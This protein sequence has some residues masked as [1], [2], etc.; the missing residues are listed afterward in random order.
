[1]GPSG[2]RGGRGALG[3]RLEYTCPR[4][5]DPPWVVPSGSGAARTCSN[6]F[7]SPCSSR[8]SEVHQ[9]SDLNL[10]VSLDINSA[11]TLN[12]AVISKAST[13]EDPSLV[14]ASD[15]A[16]LGLASDRGPGRIGIG[17]LAEK[18]GDLRK[19]W[20]GSLERIRATFARAKT[21]VSERIAEVIVLMFDAL[22]RSGPK[23]VQRMHVRNVTIAPKSGL[24]ES[25]RSIGNGPRWLVVEGNVDAIWLGQIRPDLAERGADRRKSAVERY[26]RLSLDLDLFI[27]L[28][29]V[30]RLVTADGLLLH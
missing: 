1:V 11:G 3:T 10:E 26:D 29:L 15:V 2:R 22:I 7:H 13:N 30:D 24:Q 9:Y 6:T 4:N 18:F 19:I 20:S 8:F 21:P 17:A 28:E 23:E 5:P 16:S 25:L 12:R 14:A 27:H